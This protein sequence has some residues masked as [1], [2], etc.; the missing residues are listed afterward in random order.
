MTTQTEILEEFYEPQ[1]KHHPS[2]A[3]IRREMGE[4][5]MRCRDC[6]ARLYSFDGT[7]DADEPCPYGKNC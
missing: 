6:G 5:Y 3:E 4:A 7:Q 1:R 2:P